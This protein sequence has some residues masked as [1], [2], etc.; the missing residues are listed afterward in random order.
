MA[1][2]IGTC[3]LCGGAVTLPACWMDLAVPPVPTCTTCGAT[4]KQPHGL[5]IEMEKRLGTSSVSNSSPSVRNTLIA[6]VI[7]DRAA[8]AL[9]WV[10]EYKTLVRDAW[11]LKK[12]KGE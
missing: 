11:A 7:P 2:I 12:P 6:A 10:E 8:D 3:S 1:F 9:R 4:K 5:V